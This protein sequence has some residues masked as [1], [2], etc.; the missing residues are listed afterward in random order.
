MKTLLAAHARV[1]GQAY[2]MSRVMSGDPALDAPVREHMRVTVAAFEKKHGGKEV[3]ALD[4]RPK[5]R[6]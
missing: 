6:A 4:Q 3:L 2:E 5:E 1:D